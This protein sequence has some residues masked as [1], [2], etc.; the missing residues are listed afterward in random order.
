MA[1]KLL[2][3][4]LTVA[5]IGGLNAQAWKEKLNQAKDKLTGGTPLTQEEAGRGL[6]EALDAGVGEAVSFLSA[7]D[8]YY[9]SI[10][11]IL[12]PEEAQQ[13]ANRL[14]AV[15]GFS[16]FEEDALMKI[17]RAAEDAAQKAKPIFVSAIKQMTFQDAMN[18]LMGNKDAATRYLE[19]S[20]YSQLYDEFRPVVIE[21]LDKFNARTYWHDGVTAYNKIPLVSK[22]NPELD[23]YVTKQALL[24][25]FS[26][27]E[28]KELDIRE[29][30]SARTTELLRKVFAKQD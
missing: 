30:T 29:N 13:V 12:L 22:A 8:G 1:K 15:P 28:T 19:K 10:Y 27:I 4:I 16:N 17:N 23:D 20:T 18:I 24:G 3:F 21:S 6:K 9:K 7:E 25:L 5:I 14:R 11:K 2:V 26:L